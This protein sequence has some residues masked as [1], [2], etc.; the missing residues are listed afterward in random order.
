M[1]RCPECKIP[2]D[3]KG[4]CVCGW[5]ETGR[6]AATVRCRDCS[7]EADIIRPDQAMSKDDKKIFANDWGLCWNHY[8]RWTRNRDAD[9]WRDQD[10]DRI[11]ADLMRNDGEPRSEWLARLGKSVQENDYGAIV[12]KLLRVEYAKTASMGKTQDGRP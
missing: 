9:D 2:I 3:G 6:K 7:R 1:D 12:R 4:A 10:V 8:H 5:R 11:S